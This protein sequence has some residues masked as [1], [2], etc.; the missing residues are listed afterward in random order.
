LT[1][2]AYQR[3]FQRPAAAP[4]A[5]L[6]PVPTFGQKDPLARTAIQA[7]PTQSRTAPPVAQPEPQ[8]TSRQQ[9]AAHGQAGLSMVQAGQ[10]GAPTP[11]ARNL[12]S[13]RAPRATGPAAAQEKRVGLPTPR[14]L[15]AER[16]AQPER[17]PHARPGIAAPSAPSARPSAR[18]APAPAAVA[19]KQSK[20]LVYTGIFVLAAIGVGAIVAKVVF[21]MF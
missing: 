19:P 1:Q 2:T 13:A 21:S 20:S 3:G 11:G 10:H 17:Q 14:S 16:P 18:S 15:A 7:P 8:Q 4:N 6:P 5:A 9:Q 12:A